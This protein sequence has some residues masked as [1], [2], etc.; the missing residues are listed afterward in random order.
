MISNAT[1]NH[2]EISPFATFAASNYDCAA[3]GAGNYNDSTLCTTQ[4]PN[5]G[6][7]PSD[8]TSGAMPVGGIAGI[9]LGAVLVVSG[10]IV[11]IKKRHS[12]HST[13]N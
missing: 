13:S 6:V 11:L 8:S 5:T 4:A 2:I 7:A 1:T 12:A 3:Y 10:I 9:V